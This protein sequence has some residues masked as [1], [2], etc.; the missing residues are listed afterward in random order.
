[1]QQETTKANGQTLNA[2]SQFISPSSP[3]LATNHPTDRPTD[4]PTHP[5]KLP[6]MH[7]K[8]VALLSLCVAA[9]VLQATD[10]GVSP[11]SRRH[12]G[13]KEDY[14]HHPRHHDHEKK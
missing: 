10:A 5:D 3:H 6:N 11:V 7:S 2:L 4:A 12:L 13:S 8:I 14:A 1:M 9:S